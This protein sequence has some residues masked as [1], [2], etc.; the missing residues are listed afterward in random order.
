M[1]SFQYKNCIFLQGGK[2]YWRYY[3]RI[4][5]WSDVFMGRKMAGDLNQKGVEKLTSS[6]RAAGSVR[7]PAGHVLVNEKYQGSMLVKV[8]KGM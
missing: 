5:S 8:L 6:Q 3:G 4:R 1:A 2:Y 7:I